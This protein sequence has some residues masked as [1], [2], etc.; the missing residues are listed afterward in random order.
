MGVFLVSYD[1]P[2]YGASTRVPGRRVSDAATDVAAIA[3]A[4]GLERFAIVGRSGGGP[5]ALACAALLPG[6]VTRCAALVSIAPPDAPGLAWF[7]GMARSNMDEY[8][9]A[10]RDVALFTE[11]LLA[12]ADRT[13]RDP[14]RLM[15]ELRAELTH[16]DLRV[17][18]DAVMRRLITS[19]YAEAMRVGGHGW[20]DDALAFRSEWGFQLTEVTGEVLLWHGAD[21]SFSPVG[22]T[23]WLAARIPHAKVQV[24]ADTAH[25]GAVEILPHALAWLTGGA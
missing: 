9:T 1:R 15:N 18:D 11:Q 25:F 3:D 4:L 13:R 23:D 14:E 24:Q 8:G 7:D 12:R 5:H 21:D 20:V 6:R 17:I 22:H 10:D 2:G 16:S 19:T